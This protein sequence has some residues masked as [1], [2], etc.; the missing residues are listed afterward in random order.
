MTDAKCPRCDS[1]H[2]TVHGFKEHFAAKHGRHAI[3]S[4]IQKAIALAE[5]GL[6]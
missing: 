2:D 1:Y 3:Y 6:S 5:E 4:E